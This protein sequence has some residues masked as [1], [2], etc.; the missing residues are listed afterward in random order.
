MEVVP[1]QLPVV[2]I[3]VLDPVEAAGPRAEFAVAPVEQQVPAGAPETRLLIDPRGLGGSIDLVGR[4]YVVPAPRPDV[5]SQ[6]PG[7]RPE[8]EPP[9]SQSEDAVSAEVLVAVVA[10]AGLR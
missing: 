9:E 3:V 2:V 4:D 5:H 8:L 6:Q 1:A 7:A 10:P